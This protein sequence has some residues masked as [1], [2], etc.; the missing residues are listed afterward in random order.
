[1]CDVTKAL[2]TAAGATAHFNGNFNT[3]YRTQNCM[4]P[5]TSRESVSYEVHVSQ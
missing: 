2:L 4:S 3:I 5:V 1:M